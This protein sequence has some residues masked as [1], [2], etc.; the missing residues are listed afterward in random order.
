MFAP[1]L[2]IAL[3]L[4]GLLACAPRAVFSQA[5]PSPSQDERSLAALFDAVER[6]RVEREV[7]RPPRVV[8]GRAEIVPE[9]GARAFALTDGERRCG[10]L[11]IGPSRLRYRVE[12]RYSIPVARRNLRA[13]EG[14]GVE[15]RDEALEISARLRGA[16]VWGDELEFGEA[17][18]GAPLPAL[19]EWASRA[20][21]LQRGSNPARD[22]LAGRAN[23]DPG[24]RWALFE[25]ERGTLVL[26]VDPRR[27]VQ[28]TEFLARLR[29]PDA[30]ETRDTDRLETIELAAQPIGREWGEVQGVEFTVTET[31]IELVNPAG[32]VAVVTARSR[33]VAERDGL[34]L[35]QLVLVPAQRDSRGRL[36]PVTLESVTV[37]GAPVESLW[38]G[39]SLLVRLPKPL[40]RG[41][42]VWIESR[43]RG[44]V[45]W[46]PEGNSYWLLGDFAW[47]PRPG[48]G[49][50][51][52][53]SFR[54]S[55]ESRAPFV[56]IAPGREIERSSSAGVNRVR[57][58]LAGSHTHLSVLAGDYT[59]LTEAAAGMK[60]EVASYAFGK[61][62]EARLVGRNVLA[63]R[64]C[65][66]EWLGVPYPF[67]DVRA[68]EVSS[69]G[70]GQAPAG[71]L[72]LTREQFLSAAGSRLGNRN[73]RMARLTGAGAGSRLAHEVAHGWFPHVVRLRGEE[74]VWLS[75]SFAD[76]VSAVCVER[77]TPDPEEARRSFEQNLVEWRRLSSF[78]GDDASLMLV[79][80][81]AP[82]DDAALT[83][84]QLLYGKG[85]LVLHALRDEVARRASTPELGEKQFLSWFRALAHAAG[86]RATGTS[87]AI[88][89]LERLTASSYRPWFE[90][91]VYGTETPAL[92][93]PA[94]K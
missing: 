19:P 29:R 32:E 73:R 17:L 46:R 18:S 51:E 71:I 48:V 58:E 42:S 23:G 93:S 62:D 16:A 36:R 55:I 72:L 65:L 49:G 33:I 88:R 6:P 67:P 69:W 43:N 84:H 20:L 3:V 11:L 52:R 66:E 50:D 12:D 80:H 74:N 94:A 2:P 44:E 53:S 54:L 59:S 39:V 82:S 1:V 60:A 57:T 63:I 64:G 61:G 8:V 85:P 24:F 26:D 10:L 56:P 5:S 22:L 47:Y 75:E 37:D 89:L 38:R 90:R 15:L 91:F 4:L 28:A 9:A 83:R 45:L 81:L 79:D 35:V 34:S 76:Y 27:A 87:D 86:G 21:D 14:L 78:L 25:T 77:M 68:V 70:W 30:R 13:A 31:E 92:D 7:A 40:R 41:E